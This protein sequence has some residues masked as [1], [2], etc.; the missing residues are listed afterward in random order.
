M[1]TTAIEPGQ[2][3]RRYRA[4]AAV[5]PEFSS[6]LLARRQHP[7]SFPTPATL[8]SR[9][10]VALN[11]SALESLALSLRDMVDRLH[12][13]ASEVQEDDDIG[14]ELREVQRQLHMASRRLD[15]SLRRL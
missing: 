5:G 2:S 14:S 12:D 1:E 8:E 4:A 7:V 9:F 6:P 11:S 3:S 13:L 10:R 15:K